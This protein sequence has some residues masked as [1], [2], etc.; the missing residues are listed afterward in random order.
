M[1]RLDSSTESAK[2]FKLLDG[3]SEIKNADS[4]F[5]LIDHSS[6]AKQYYTAQ[7]E[8]NDYNTIRGVRGQIVDRSTYYISS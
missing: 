4:P 3:T 7:A 5:Y 8:W 1:I 2:S 6:S